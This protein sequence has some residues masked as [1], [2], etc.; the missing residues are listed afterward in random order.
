MQVQWNFRKLNQCPEP[1]TE[2]VPEF[3]MESTQG[4]RIEVSPDASVR[5]ALAEEWVKSYPSDT[6][7]LIIAHGN[8]AATDFVLRLA[9]SRGAWLGARRLNLNVLAARLAQHALVAAGT[10]PA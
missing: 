4:P 1:Q 10:A 9:Q 5:L 7:L 2:P 6:D 8:E 3:F